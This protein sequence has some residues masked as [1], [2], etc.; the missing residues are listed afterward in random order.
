MT[1]GLPNAT[2]NIGIIGMF[3]EFPFLYVI[4]GKELP[5]RFENK[6]IDE[7]F[8][9]SLKYIQRYYESMLGVSD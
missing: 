2:I 6:E 1:G 5:N 3:H 8:V 7:A 9:V 4:G